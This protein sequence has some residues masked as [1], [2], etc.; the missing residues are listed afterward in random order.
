MS[1]RSTSSMLD[2]C[3]D[4][5]LC[6]RARAPAIMCCPSLLTQFSSGSLLLSPPHSSPREPALSSD[7]PLH[8]CP[9]V[10]RPNPDGPT[11]SILG[12]CD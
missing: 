9:L 11:Q 8:F 5:F 1:P 7:L 10:S 12:T 3:L 2:S 6:S 4:L